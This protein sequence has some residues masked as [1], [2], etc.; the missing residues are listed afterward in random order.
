MLDVC[1]NQVILVRSRGCRRR[2]VAIT[3]SSAIAGM[4]HEV[5]ADALFDWLRTPSDASAYSAMFCVSMSVGGARRS[6]AR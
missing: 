4:T 1:G 5:R 6:I 2:L 3:S